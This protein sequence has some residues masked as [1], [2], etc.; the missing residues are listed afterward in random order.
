M[1]KT[2]KGS[3][4][5]KLADKKNIIRINVGGLGRGKKRGIPRKLSNRKRSLW[6]GSLWKRLSAEIARVVRL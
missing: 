6:K 1:L 5:E 2:N 3:A 4:S